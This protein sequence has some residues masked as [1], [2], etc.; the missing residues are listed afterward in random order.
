MKTLSHKALVTTEIITSECGKFTYEIIKKIEAEN[1]KGGIGLF[2]C[3]YPTKTKDTLYF[4]DSTSLYLTEHAQ[5]LGFSEIHLVNI[6]STVTTGRMSAKGLIPDKVNLDY[7]KSIFKR[8]NFS[9][10][11]TVISWG[12]SLETNNAT[13]ESKKA[14]LKC[15]F[16]TNPDKKLYQV[17]CPEKA[18]F[19]ESLHPLF[20]GLRCKDSKLQ[21]I[22]YSAD[23][24]LKPD[25][26]EKANG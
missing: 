6:F 16:E 12:T 9:D 4:D 3:L 14:I 21:L 17:I 13:N 18:I 8:K 15:F 10:Y 19:S 23:K 1:I 26:K 7:I 2:I 20:L 24:Y 11:T 25:T 5:D 22:E